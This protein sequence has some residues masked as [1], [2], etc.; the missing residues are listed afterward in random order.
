[1]HITR[2]RRFLH[3]DQIKEALA[4]KALAKEAME[5]GCRMDDPTSHYHAA[6]LFKEHNEDGS[7]RYTSVWLYHMTKAAAT[8]HPKAA[9]ALA[10]F[11]SETVWKYIEDEPP[12]YLKP[13][14]FDSYPG[15]SE[16]SGM[17]FQSAGGGVGDLAAK[18]ASFFSTLRR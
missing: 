6:E 1:L 3:K 8:G 7:A 17:P 2:Y 12:D 5:V 15:P 11:Y 10:V 13:T 16:I 9:H 18:M 14:P 4:E